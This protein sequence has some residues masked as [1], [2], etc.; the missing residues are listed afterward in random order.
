M[1][2][3]LLPV[4]ILLFS[5]PVVAQVNARLFQFPDVSETQITFVYAGDIWVVSK[6]GGTAQR[7]SSPKGNELLPKFS[8]DGKTIAFTGNYNGNND[9]YTIPANGGLP[10]R[11]TNHPST[12]RMLAWYPGGDNILF[13]STRRSGR[14]RFNQ[15]YKIS[16]NGGLP[17]KLPVPYGE[18]GEISKD[19]K[20][21]AYTKRTRLFRT[22]KRYRGGTAPNIWI[23]NLKDYSSRNITNNDA[24]NELPMWAGENIYY[25]SDNGPAERFNIWVYNLNNKSSKQITFFKNFDIRFPSIGPGNIVFEAGGKMYLLNLKSKKYTEVKIKVVTD[26]ISLLPKK[27]KVS[28]YTQNASIAYNGKRVIV[29]ARGD[30]FSLPAKHGPVIDLTR[31]SGIAE[32]Y[33]AWSPDGKYLVYWSDKTG[34]YE[35]TLKDFTKNG[36][37]KTLTEYGPGFRYNI[38]WS[39]DSKKIAFI[40]KAMVIKIYN[41][42]TDKT[43]FVDKGL[44]MYEGD[45]QGFRVGWS[46]DSRYIAYSRGVDNKNNAV[47]IFDTQSKKKRQVTTGYYSDYDPAF[48]VEGKYLYFLTSRTFHPLYSSFENTWIYTNSSTIAAVP[49][50]K[51]TASPLSNRNDE[52]KPKVEKKKDKKNDKKDSKKKDKAKVKPVKIDFNGFES[53][54]VSLP[55]KAGRY[56]NLST[57]KG[58]I[59]Y[60][61]YPNNGSSDKKID[62][63]YYDLKDRKEKT[64]IKGINSYQLSA[65]GKKILVVKRGKNP[66]ASVIDVKPN[67][68]MKDMLPLNQMEMTINPR[69]EWKQIFTDAWRFERDYFYDPNMHGVDWEAVKEKYGKLLNDV[70][71]RSGLNFVIGELIGE[72]SSSHTYRSGGDLQRGK[73]E[74]TGLLGINWTLNNGAFQIKKIIHGASW[75]DNV[76]SPLAEP[77]LKVKVGDYILAVNDIPLNTK[78]EPY[79]A[80]QGLAGKTIKL[81]VNSK[82]DYEGAK[83]IYVKTLRS[84]SRLRHLA[85]IEANREYV[86]KKSNG[87]IGYVYVRST[88]LDGQSELVR[89]FLAQV[90]KAGLIIDERFNSGGQIPDR[91]IELLDRKPLAFWAVR[92]GKNWQ[93]PPTANFGPKAMLIN[94]W[95]GSGG[96]AFPDYFRKRKLGPLI[97][98]RTWGGLIGYTGVPNLIDGGRVTVPTFR[99]YNPDGK[100]F[101]EGYGVAP[102]IKVMDDPTLMAEGKRPQLNAAIKYV[103]KQIKKNPNPEPKQP[104][105]EKR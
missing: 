60:Q 45:L 49:L 68:K 88:G 38:F 67:Q 77:G 43:T 50:T 27:E 94:G 72:I 84:E 82:P 70:V 13:A 40:N 75:D 21:L 57:V 87:K 78:K 76:R 6:E 18:F 58:K 5:L 79:S 91:F 54:I 102:D 103:L 4:L 29:Q 12:D 32:R 90:D 31:T 8:P 64:I 19:G 33:P 89:Q 25:L 99:M 61:K 80:F 24:N 83:S 10:V 71:T 92:D 81:T 23:F 59:I 85:W 20:W 7:L 1:K 101:R 15:L 93:W 30:L 39:P 34:E 52:V 73:R 66:K 98:M 47:F 2:K 86:E 100:W 3:F 105:Y 14:Q 48:D 65:N 42:T 53:R 11:V 51:E 35:L 62:L 95:S 36:S 9:I 41:F 22:W 104:P 28:A 96:D 16:K 56:G 55:P 63:V 69:K 44:Y 37:E 74:N 97:G 17:E 26:E 46:P